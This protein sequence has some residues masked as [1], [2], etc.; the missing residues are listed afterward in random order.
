MDE[1]INIINN[2]GFPMTLSI[3]L[4]LH[5][6]KKIDALTATIRDLAEVINSFNIEKQ[7]FY[8]RPVNTTYKDIY[9]N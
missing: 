3:Y 7:L 6:E 4:L 2:I 5:F 1:I 9:T 8:M